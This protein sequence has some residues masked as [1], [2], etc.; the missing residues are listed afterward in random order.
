M[1]VEWIFRKIAISKICHSNKFKT[2]NCENIILKIKSKTKKKLSYNIATFQQLNSFL[3]RNK[4]Y[5][6][7]NY[8]KI[9]QNRKNSNF[10]PK[11]KIK[12]LRS[13][14]KETS[15]KKLTCQNNTLQ[16]YLN[17]NVWFYHGFNMNNYKLISKNIQLINLE[18][19]ILK[20]PIIFVI[21]N[22]QKEYIIKVLKY[23]IKI[24]KK[25]SLKPQK[26]QKNMFLF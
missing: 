12:I 20:K 19:L 1:I 9:F 13:H 15:I 10:I 25:I 3:L 23:I 5:L 7:K 26:S 14:Y 22:I 2:I 17:K 24:K 18:F 11:E 4:F 21:I 6:I 16:I 8:P